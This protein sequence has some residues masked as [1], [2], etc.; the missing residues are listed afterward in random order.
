MALV[1]RG[2]LRKVVSRQQLATGDAVRS[3]RHDLALE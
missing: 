1:N 2:K 3:L